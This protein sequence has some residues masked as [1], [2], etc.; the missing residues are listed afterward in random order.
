MGEISLS[1]SSSILIQTSS[2]RSCSS[3]DA[4]N[5]ESIKKRSGDLFCFS[6][7][8]DRLPDLRV[9][10]EA[11]DSD[12]ADLFTIA[13]RSDDIRIRNGT[14]FYYQWQNPIWWY[15]GRIVQTKNTRVWETQDRI[16][17][18]WPGDSSEESWTWLSQIED[19]GE[20]MYRAIFTNYEFWGQKRKLG[21]KR[22]GQGSGVKTA[23]TKNFG[24]LLAME[25]QRAVFW[26]RQLQFPSGY[27]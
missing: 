7:K 17:I 1:A 21:K 18:V 25:N 3:R 8:T 26:R 11:N 24:R 6:W 20:K 27:Q 13:L 22:R 16:V 19:N 12:Y 23:W 2:F 14:E 15:L 9:L 4:R 10:P 5:S